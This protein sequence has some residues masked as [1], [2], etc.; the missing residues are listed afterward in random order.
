MDRQSQIREFLSPT[1]WAHATHVVMNADASNRSYRRLNLDAA[2]AIL[3]DAPVANNEPISIFS[4]ITHILR[5]WGFSAPRVIA[6][7]NET[8]LMLLE[9]LGDALF[10]KVCAQHPDD[11]HEIYAAAVDLLVEL[12]QK[13]APKSIADYDQTTYLKEAALLTDWYVAHGSQRACPTQEYQTIVGGLSDRLDQTK[14]ILVLR[15]Y[16]AENLIW[17][18][19]RAGPARVGLLDYQDALAGHRAYDLVSLL[20]DARRDTSDALQSEMKSRY[21]QKTGI[22][23]EQFNHD[24]A[25]LGAQRNLKIVGI[26]ARLCIRD[27]KSHYVD[28][29]PRVW[30]HLQRDLSHQGLSELR[31][32]VDEHVPAPNPDVLASLKSANA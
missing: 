6:E 8:G 28:L 7:Q 15:D 4:S 29:I 30:A 25:V 26:F 23:A 2:S 16:H 9:D 10:A 14:P 17:L 24:Y 31:D 19:D 21:I 32:W 5:N 18:P 12:H 13:P 27:R 20:E 1:P 3:M 11:E 22:N